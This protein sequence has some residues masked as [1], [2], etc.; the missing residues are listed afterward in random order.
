MSDKLEE[1]IPEEVNEVIEELQ[2]GCR[3]DRLQPETL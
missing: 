2:P 3:T 1:E